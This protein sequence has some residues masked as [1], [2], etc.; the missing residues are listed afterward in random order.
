LIEAFAD[1]RVP[2]SGIELF[3][4]RVEHSVP[5]EAQRG[6]AAASAAC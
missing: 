3:R 6:G 2:F 4:G 1:I 5:D